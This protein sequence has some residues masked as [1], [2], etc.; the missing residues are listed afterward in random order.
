MRPLSGATLGRVPRVPVN[1]LISRTFA[2][3]PMGFKE[4]F[5]FKIKCDYLEVVNPLVAI[6]NAAPELTSQNGPYCL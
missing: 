1:P 5:K 4:L 2:S 6:P 3:E